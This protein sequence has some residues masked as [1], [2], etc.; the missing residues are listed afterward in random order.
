MVRR[1]KRRALS[2]IYQILRLLESSEKVASQLFFKVVHQD[3]LINKIVVRK[4]DDGSI[5]AMKCLKKSQIKRDNKV[6]HV[7]NERQILQNVSHPFIVKMH[8]AF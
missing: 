4:K 3:F 2:R 5:F 7:M 1:N 8:W 6:R